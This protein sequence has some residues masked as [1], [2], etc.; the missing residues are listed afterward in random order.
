MNSP[1][2]SDISFLRFFSLRFNSL[3]LKVRL[4]V[5]KRWFLFHRQNCSR[6]LLHREH[7]V[8]PMQNEPD[9]DK[10]PYNELWHCNTFWR[11]FSRHTITHNSLC[12]V[13]R[14]IFDWQKIEK[15]LVPRNTQ[16]FSIA[17]L[18]FFFF[19]SLPSPSLNDIIY[20]EPCFLL[21][22]FVWHYLITASST[23]PFL[24]AAS[25]FLYGHICVPVVIG[26]I[27]RVLIHGVPLKI[28]ERRND[29]KITVSRIFAR[30]ISRKKKH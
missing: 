7:G 28:Y 8:T 4:I 29:Y 13:V 24:Y 2:N 10:S 16:I 14:R 17:S 12:V 15:I 21:N 27:V 18:V 3:S 26:E 9:S 20:W 1:R 25:D 23:Q 11:L 30:D 5:G 19:L 6:Y 22:F